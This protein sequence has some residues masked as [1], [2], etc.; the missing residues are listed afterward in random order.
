MIFCFFLGG[1]SVPTA[2]PV[3]LFE[4]LWVVDRLACL[5]ISRYFVHEIKNCLDYA[6]R[7]WTEE[8]ICWARNSPVHDVDDTAMGF[9]LLR[10]HGYDVSSNVFR[11]FE[12]DGEFICFAGQ[13]SQAVTGMFNLNR[14]AQLLFPERRY[15]SALRASPTR[16]FEKSKLATSSRISGSSPRICRARMA[17]VEYALDFPWYANLPRIETRLYRDQYGGSSDVWI[18][19]IL[20]RMPVVNND[21]YLELAK[22]DFNQCQALHQ[23]EW[24][25][26]QMWYEENGLG[27]YGVNKKSMLRA[28]FLAVSSIFEPDRAAER[29]GWARTA[30]LADAVSAYFCSKSCTEEM[31]LHFICD[32]LRDDVDKSCD[33]NWIRSGMEKT[34]EGLLGLLRQLINRLTFEAVPPP[35]LERHAT[36]HHLRQAW[37]QWLVTWREEGRLDGPTRGRGGRGGRTRGCFWA[38][39]WRSAGPVRSDGSGGGPAGGVAEK[40]TIVNKIDKEVDSEMQELVQCVLQS[41]SNLNNTTKQTFLSVVKSFYYLAHCP[42]ATLN[43]HISKV[44]F[45]RVV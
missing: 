25:G 34:E 30:V 37:H 9:R 43:T 4:H 1:N 26:L 19:K 45:H 36:R 7:Y 20:Y 23:L 6:S 44:I 16:S 42:Y 3:D 11:K 40:D 21:L 14:A 13:S 33:N 2:Y 8:G 35:P 18:G 10:L 32:F 29:L 27:K 12:K 22:A 24:L 39:R 28:Y 17:K 5:G 15:W 41:S 31:R 38:G